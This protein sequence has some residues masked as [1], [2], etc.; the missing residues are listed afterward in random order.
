M[1]NAVALTGLNLGC[2]N[3]NE[4]EGF[5]PEGGRGHDTHIRY[6]DQNNGN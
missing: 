5:L 6:I 1:V 4:I 2:L 3:M